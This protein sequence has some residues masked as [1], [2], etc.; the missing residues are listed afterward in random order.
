MPL[1][2][3]APIRAAASDLPAGKL[4]C[5]RPRPDRDGGAAAEPAHQLVARKAQVRLESLER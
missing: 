2:M 1:L 4:T 3:S 5:R